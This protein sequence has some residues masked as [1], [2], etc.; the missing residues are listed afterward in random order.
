M[1]PEM[2]R[3]SMR[4]SVS[5]RSAVAGA[6]KAAV[7]AP[8]QRTVSRGPVRVSAVRLR[9]RERDAQAGDQRA[10]RRA[11]RAAW[12]TMSNRTLPPM[13]GVSG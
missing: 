4:C 6:P 1:S 10:P 3:I 2:A 12:T 5:H 7:S 8:V 11:H 13:S 9:A